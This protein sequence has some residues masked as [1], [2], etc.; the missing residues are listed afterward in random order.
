MKQSIASLIIITILHLSCQQD[1]K[2][3]AGF[4]QDAD[5]TTL[6][7][8]LSEERTGINFSNN[9]PESDYLNG[10]LYE[11]YYN[12]GGV[13]I[14]DV[15]NDGFDDIYFTSNL[16][17]NRLY[18]NLGGLVFKDVT[19]KAK[20]GGPKG[21]SN[22]ATM[23]DLNQD[24]LLDIYVCQSGA[25]TDENYRKNELYINH[26]ADL[27][28]IPVFEESA[29]LYGLDDPS[30]SVQAAFFDFDL[31]GDLDLFLANHNRDAPPRSIDKV[32]D[33][34]STPSPFGGNKLYRNNNQSFEDI[35][36]E[37]G[38]H[39]NK[40]NFTLGI[41]ISDINSDNWPD[42]YVANDYSEPDY[43]YINN[44]DGSFNEVS[45]QSF[46]H[47]P[48]ASMGT[49]IADINNDGWLDIMS[50][51]MAAADN[52]GIKTSMS[53][54]NPESFMGHVEAGLHHQYMY[55]ALQLN[56]GVGIDGIPLFSE[57]GQIAGV[58]ST[59]WSWAPL[60]ADFDNDGY[61]DIF[62]TNGVKRDFINNDFNIFLNQEIERITSLKQ[63]P[64][65]YF[66]Q[67][68][69]S[70]PT[71]EKTNYIYKNLGDLTF[72]NA[73]AE[74]GLEEVSLSNGS[75]YADLDNDGDL[76]LVVNNVD[77]PAGI[78]ENTIDMRGPH[79][80]N[81]KLKGPPNN[82][83]GIGTKIRV[84]VDDKIQVLEQ[85]PTRGYLSSVPLTLHFGLGDKKELN[86]VVVVWPDGK[87]QELRAIAANQQLVID[88]QNA[89]IPSD[90]ESEYQG[91]RLFDDISNEIAIDFSHQENIYDD[92][93]REGLLPHK[94]SQQGPGLA[95]ADVNGDGLDDF[96][97]GG[98]I[99]NS[100]KMFIQNTSGKFI[101]S[102][103][104][105]WHGDRNYEDVDA[106]FFDPDNDGD[107]D[108]MVVSGGNEYEAGSNYYKSRIYENKGDGSFQR[109]I[110][111][112]QMPIVSGSVVRPMDFDGD[113]DAD[114][115]IG[116]RQSP[117]NYPFPTGSFLL[118]NDSEPGAIKFTD[119]TSTQIKELE[120]IGMVTDAAWHDL[121]GD[122][123]PE[124]IIC[125]EW[126]GIKVFRNQ[127]AKF[128]DVS[129][130]A[131]LALQT[132]WWYAIAA[133]DFDN[134]GD[135]DLV[136]GNHGLNSKY[137]TSPEEPFQIYTTDFDNNGIYDIV[138]GYYNEGQLFPL[139]GKECTS[140]QMPFV[141]NKF[142]SYEAFGKAT[143]SE[144]YGVEN[145]TNAL[146][147]QVNTFATTYFENKGSLTFEAK[148]LSNLAQISSVKSILSEDFDKDGNI[149]IVLAGNFYETE[150]ETPRNDASYGLFMKGDGHGVFKSV[151]PFES[152]LYV[153]GD[154]KK[155]AFIKLADGTTCI[156]FARNGAEPRV[157]KVN[158][159]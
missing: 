80:I 155:S 90:I 12:G 33:L 73:T 130:E 154:V 6:F 129:S 65:N 75:A 139:R 117:G 38:I 1:Q 107:L 114:L 142:T 25:F 92:F 13:A 104:S 132:G 127:G 125:G 56:N 23:I 78:Y 20:V 42:I 18:L 41:S 30:Y 102:N 2:N 24:G 55:N 48:N 110:S 99:G 145:L 62:I 128:Y 60:L 27:D 22:G 53:S 71:R 121:D 141:K 68:T 39:A 36:A 51:D 116:G 131:G 35:T 28:G 77:A 137:H 49:D 118:R 82:N 157:I 16:D 15:N 59:D 58:A 122:G 88:Y 133:S 43:L 112:G 37:A 113:G 153:S 44:G 134:D 52:F 97:I 45:Q 91:Q 146:H 10:F 54:M 87:R 148:P 84:E 76:D 105:F 103:P 115:F 159:L 74:W 50:L 152:G 147:Y 156:L 64:L 108:L 149:D 79:Y 151:S 57:I 5:G 101:A 72:E 34:H 135:T 123:L 119:V 98:S 150:V 144:V 83:A 136:I 61:K 7:R 85:Y 8:K 140:N 19:N 106:L 111:T 3:D 81:F 143:L 126:M 63:D 17:S 46:G 95:V 94:M 158:D 29:S 32:I 109:S 14:G 31:D 120:N 4:N 100:G 93:K 26:G 124:L 47:I 138:L 66:A 40:M 67:L 69:Q 9:L 70:A 11:Y 96:Y 86:K 89:T 21:W